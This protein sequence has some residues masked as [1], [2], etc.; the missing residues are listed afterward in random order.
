LD[1]DL[2]RIE[3]GIRTYEKQKVFVLKGGDGGIEAPYEQAATDGNNNEDQA[4]DDAITDRKPSVVSLAETSSRKVSS[5]SSVGGDIERKES[6]DSGVCGSRKTSADTSNA[7]LD[8]KASRF[9]M[10]AADRKA[11]VLSDR[12][13]SGGSVVF[14]PEIEFA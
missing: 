12:K 11:S 10:A 9:S 2:E 1:K 8:K 6:R 7:F 5:G 4:E 13:A 3:E 14:A